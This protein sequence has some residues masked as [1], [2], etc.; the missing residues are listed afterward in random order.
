MSS[1][2][3]R[4]T[5]IKGAAALAALGK[6]AVAQTA[7]DKPA[8]LCIFLNGGYNAL[9]ASHDSFQGAGTFGCSAGNGK[10]LGNGLVV[11]AATYGTMPAFAL[12]HMASVG[13]RHGLTAHEAHQLGRLF[14]EAGLHPRVRDR[15][16]DEDRLVAAHRPLRTRLEHRHP[17]VLAPDLERPELV[18]EAGPVDFDAGVGRAVPGD[19][20]MDLV[21][22]PGDHVRGGGPAGG[23]LPGPG[24]ADA[25]VRVADD[26]A[27]AGVGV[28]LAVLRPAGGHR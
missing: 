20:D 13:I 1:S 6:T 7:P 28:A 14:G 16:G 21:A 8:L 5:L 18:A 2:F 22:G 27:T 9:F 15:L 4:R 23:C 10:D 24:T 26:R 25:P 19:E 11:D 3:S 17:G 12:S